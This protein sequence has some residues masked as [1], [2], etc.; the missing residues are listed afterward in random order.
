MI[1]SHS[2]ISSRI[3][4]NIIVESSSMI[5]IGKFQ[6]PEELIYQPPMCS[7]QPAWQADQHDIGY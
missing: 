7:V 4:P 1:A 2:K 3:A 5:L 6:L